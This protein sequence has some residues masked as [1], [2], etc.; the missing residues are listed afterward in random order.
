MVAWARSAIRYPGAIRAGASGPPPLAYRAAY[1]ARLALVQWTPVVRRR[2]VGLSTRLNPLVA[3]VLRSP[4][5]WLLSPGLLLITVTGRKTGRSYTIPVG[6]HRDGDA[7]VILVAEPA[8][9]RWWRN[10]R[11]SGPIALNL[12]GRR[13]VATASVLP[14]A[15]DEYRRRVEASFRRSALIGRLFGIRFDAAAGLSGADL[16]DLADRL[17]VVEVTGLEPS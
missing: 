8:S 10:Y 13:I 9:K 2:I 7:I 6:Y 1:R 15:S 17:V 14:P 16:S 12:R 3:A 4:L 5:H 11:T